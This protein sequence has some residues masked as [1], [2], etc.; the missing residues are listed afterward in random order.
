MRSRL[1]A[2]ALAAALLISALGAAPVPAARAE[3]VRCADAYQIGRTAHLVWDGRIAFSVKQFYSPRCHARYGYA[4]AWQQFRRLKI[5]YELGLAVFDATKD[6]ID[7]AR[8][9]LGAGGGPD[10][11]S[12]PVRVAPGTCTAGLV[13]AFLPGTESDAFS[14]RICG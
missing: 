12:A 11:W 13:H 9:Y 2:R 3:A 6:A 4:H 5:H 8:T 1:A 14:G 10:F 7:G